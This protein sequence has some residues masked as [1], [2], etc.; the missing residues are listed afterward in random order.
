MNEDSSF[1]NRIGPV[2][3]LVHAM[4]DQRKNGPDPILSC[5]IE[6]GFKSRHS[7]STSGD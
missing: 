1:K 4:L 3:S 7:L 2:L 5:S 6:S